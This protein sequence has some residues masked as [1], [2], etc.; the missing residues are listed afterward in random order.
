MSLSIEVQ[1]LTVRFGRETILDGI[2]ISV[3]P[4]EVLGVVGAG[5]VG[6]TV[7]LKSIAGLLSPAS[8]AVFIGDKSITES[9]GRDLFTIRRRMGMVF[10]NYALFDFLTVAENAGFP[11]LQEEDEE[12]R[13]PREEVMTRVT[14]LLNQLGLPGT[15]ALFPEE[16]S[17]GM[18]KR[19]GLARATIHQ[20]DIV[21][22]DDPTA[23]L[24]PVTSSKIFLMISEIHKDRGST[25]V[26]ASHDVDRMMNVCDRFVVLHEKQVYFVGSRED[27]E[28]RRDDPVLSAIFFG[29]NSS[30]HR[31]A[32]TTGLETQ[33]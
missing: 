21:L 1:D 17:G 3:L 22:Y 31:Q 19:V 2:S 10:Q 26:I 28:G 25:D 29:A 4:G 23:G 5:G 33:I 30:L 16:L 6:K 7:L 14:A 11:L 8:G 13:L 24:D 9:I 18:K 12:L 15:E 27:V 20:P 32:P